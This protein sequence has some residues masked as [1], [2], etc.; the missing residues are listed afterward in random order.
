MHPAKQAT[1][2][3]VAAATTSLA[4]SK[5]PCPAAFG[6]W[7][8]LSHMSTSCNMKNIFGATTAT[9]AALL[10][11]A[12]AAS[13]PQ[14]RNVGK[15]NEGL[16]PVQAQSGKWGFVNQRQQWVI[17]PRFD[18]ARAFHDGKPAAKQNGK[19]GFINKQGTW[20]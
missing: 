13:G 18:E 12:C 7:G 15:F 8:L 6:R 16:A 2:P 19:W 4:A 14:Y 17:P 1:P 11:S 10:L 5:P 20:Q 3:A 9:V